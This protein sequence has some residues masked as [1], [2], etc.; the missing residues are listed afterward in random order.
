M[1]VILPDGPT[2]MGISAIDLCLRKEDVRLE[3]KDVGL[4]HSAILL[5]LVAQAPPD[6][7]RRRPAWR[8]VN[9]AALDEDLDK[10]KVCDDGELWGTLTG[11]MGRLPQSRNGER[12]CNLWNPELERLRKDT[13]RLRLACGRDIGN[14]EN[15][16]LLRAI[17]RQRICQRHHEQLRDTLQNAGD[18][19]IFKIIGRAETHKTLPPMRRADDSLATTHSHIS[20]LIAEQLDPG[21][22]SVWS[23]EIID[24]EPVDC[25]STILREGPQNS[26][27]GI[28]DIGYP[29]LIRWYKRSAGV[30]LPLINYDLRHDI[31]DW[32]TGEVVLIPN[33]NKPHY[34]VVKAWRMIHL[35]P[36][37]AK[38]AE[39]IVLGRVSDDVELDTTMFGS[40]R[41]KGV[42]DCIALAYKFF[43]ANKS[44][45]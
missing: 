10:L 5:R 14:R 19:A 38:T 21:E 31:E 25:L 3:Y 44:L 16:N 24:I 45:S 1:H 2:F 41:R 11:I 9:M 29:M 39:R 36:I 13:K 35:L 32:H 17:Y 15:Y 18:P 33:A 22:P 28:C 34:A 40:Q 12:Q 7:E 27:P 20:Y 26:T 43:D 23:P 30:V 4:Q 6:I 37:L 8:C 42:H